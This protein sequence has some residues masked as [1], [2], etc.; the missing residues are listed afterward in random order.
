MRRGTASVAGKTDVM[1]GQRLSALQRSTRYRIDW[2]GK[3]A[4][5]DSPISQVRLVE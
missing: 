2:Y 3:P 5:S 1:V 4:C